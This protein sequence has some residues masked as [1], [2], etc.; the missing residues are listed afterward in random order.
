MLLP[1]RPQTCAAGCAAVVEHRK[2]RDKRGT[3]R[4]AARSQGYPDLWWHVH[5]VNRITAN[6]GVS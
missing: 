4:G 1:N 3:F 5:T 2:G 6:E